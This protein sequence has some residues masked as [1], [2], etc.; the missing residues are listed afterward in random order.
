MGY[1][2]NTTSHNVSSRKPTRQRKMDNTT[3]RVRCPRGRLANRNNRSWS[4]GRD[5]LGSRYGNRSPTPLPGTPR[6][7]REARAR[8]AVE[9]EGKK[10][11]EKEKRRNN[12]IYGKS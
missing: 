9:K 5:N 3:P 10:N 6:R 8:E 11:D 4:K 7:V 2:N 1:R 12:P